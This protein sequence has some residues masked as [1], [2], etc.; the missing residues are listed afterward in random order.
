MN[1]FQVLTMEPDLREIGIAD[2][3]GYQTNSVL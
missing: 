3:Y 1:D 2:L